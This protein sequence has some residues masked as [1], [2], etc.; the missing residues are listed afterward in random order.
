MNDF[1]FEI[2]RKKTRSFH[3]NSFPK[4]PAVPKVQESSAL[5]LFSTR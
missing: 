3:L 1:P 2:P 4:K 5:S